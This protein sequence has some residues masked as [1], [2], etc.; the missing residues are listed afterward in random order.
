MMPM[1]AESNVYSRSLRQI[2]IGARSLL[3][4]ALDGLSLGLAQP[5]TTLSD[6]LGLPKPEKGGGRYG[7]GYLLLGGT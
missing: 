2:G 4:G 3:S 6:Y 7:A 5:G 1:G